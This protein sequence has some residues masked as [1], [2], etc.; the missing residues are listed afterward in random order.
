MISKLLFANASAPKFDNALEAVVAPVPP[1]ANAI[2]LPLHVPEVMVPTLVKLDPVI[3][4]ANVVPVNVPA[5][6]VP[7]FVFTYSVV[8]SFV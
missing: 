8:A 7:K 4:E 3:V 6:T 1:L 2:V 5:L